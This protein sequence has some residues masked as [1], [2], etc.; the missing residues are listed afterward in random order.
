M[1]DH[2]FV[3]KLCLKLTEGRNARNLLFQTFIVHQFKVCRAVVFA[4]FFKSA[5]VRAD[6]RHTGTKGTVQ[7][8]VIPFGNAPV[9]K[10]I[11]RNDNAVME[12]KISERHGYAHGF[13]VLLRA[14]SKRAVVNKSNMVQKLHGG[15]LRGHNKTLFIQI[16]K[17]FRPTFYALFSR[18][19]VVLMEA[20][21][22]PHDRKNIK[23][24][25]LNINPVLLELRIG[26]FDIFQ[27]LGRTQK[28][29]LAAIPN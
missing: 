5:A 26:S 27:S 23:I 14:E 2:L 1:P 29:V 6:I 28:R 4:Y 10:P 8:T 3:I 21:I 16:I 12:N 11:P 24:C 7:I 19:S 9:I 25:T 18:D 13:A 15:L 22:T 20:L 17:T